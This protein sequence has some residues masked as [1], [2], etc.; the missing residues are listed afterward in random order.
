MTLLET[1]S[2]RKPPAFGLLVG[3]TPQS[4]R[5]PALELL[6]R[7]DASVIGQVASAS[8]EDVADA[9]ARA[10]EAGPA[11]AAMPPSQRAAILLRAAGLFRQRAA[12]IAEIISAE[13]GKPA[14]DARVEVEKGAAILEYNAQSPY[15]TT[16]STFVTDTGEDVFTVA[17]PLGVVLLITPWNFPFTLPMRKIAAALS[18]GNTVLFKP[19]TNAALCGLAIGRTLVDAGLPSDVL[20]VIVGESSVIQEALFHDSRLAGVSLTGSYPTAEAIRRLL[21]VEVPFQAELGGKNAL[22]VWRDADLDVALDVIWQSSF[23]N[24]GQICTSCGRLLVHADIAPTLLE[25]LRTAI[26]SAAPTAPAGELGILSSEHE[27]AKI[28]AVLDGA[29]GAVGEVISADWGPDRMSPTVI[30]APADGGLITEEIFGPVITFEVVTS[31]DDAVERANATSYGL[32]AGVVTNDLEV[33]KSFWSRVKAGLV[34]VNVPLTGTPF[35]IPLRGWRNSGV[36]PGEGGEVSI[37]FFTKQKAVYLRRP[38]T[39]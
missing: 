7:H 32:T 17:E 29:N 20:S 22:L 27:F 1:L 38:P 36:G 25:R 10:A 26:T 30:V 18:T 39:A 5:G 14:G 2:P 37:D 16:G 13:M 3:G 12:E 34:K 35:H 24:N 23:R 15:R 8:P 33:A 31:I 28:R 9:Y 11:W 19:A 21:P 6:S 4:G